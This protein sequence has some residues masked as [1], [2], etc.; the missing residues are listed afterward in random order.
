MKNWI[1]WP[2]MF[3]TMSSFAQQSAKPKQ[4]PTLRSILLTELRETHNQKDWFVSEKEAVEG[5][6]PE[7]A[8]WSD[9]KNHSVGQLVA[10]LVFWNSLNLAAF[11]GE[12]PKNPADNNDT[13]KFDP[14]QWQATLKQF[15]KVMTEWEQT[16]ESAD[17]ATLQR[18]APL[19]GHISEHNAYH[20]GEM[21]A[22]R[23]EHGMWNPDLGVK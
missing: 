16:I 21:I 8:A 19:V 23:K 17:D 6:T 14:A 2:L 18:L 4:P 7:Q 1:L 20:I 13:F 10:H 15:D 5:L 11:K 12:H 9:G 22:V 3:L